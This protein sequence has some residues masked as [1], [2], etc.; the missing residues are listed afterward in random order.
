MSMRVWMAAVVLATPLAVVP[1]SSASAQIGGIGGM[2]GMGRGGMGGMGRRGGGGMRGERGGNMAD[3]MKFPSASD[4]QKFNPAQLLVDKRKDLKLSD[5]QVDTLNALRGRI[6]ERN[7]DLMA[8]YDSLQREYKP[9][10]FDGSR[11]RAQQGPDSAMQ[12]AFAQAQQLRALAD[13][14][15]ARRAIDV[16]DALAAMQTEDQRHHAAEFLQKQDNE[17]LDKL[18][19]GGAMGRGRR[20][21]GY[22]ALR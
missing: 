19:R 3:A 12:A 17:M 5:A 10:T 14:L 7:G 15:V 1:V 20:G 8:R 11:S 22:G 9:P 16:A 4:L 2:G 6:F 13:S 21:G 18:P